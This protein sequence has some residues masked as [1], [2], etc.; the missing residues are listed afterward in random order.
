MV[1]CHITDAKG[2]NV[3][4]KLKRWQLVTANKKL[5]FECLNMEPWLDS[6][7]PLHL[8]P[9]DGLKRLKLQGELFTESSGWVE[10]TSKCDQ[11][12]TPFSLMKVRGTFCTLSSR[13]TITQEGC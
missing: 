11:Q 10:F 2:K 5:F 4:I 8:R 1:S 13:A 7:E 3:D 12:I 9:T 6:S